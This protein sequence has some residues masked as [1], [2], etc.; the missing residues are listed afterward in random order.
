MIG[1]YSELFTLVKTTIG[2]QLLSSARVAHVCMY[3][4]TIK[5][6]LNLRLILCAV[7]FFFISAFFEL[8]CIFLYAS[9]FPRLACVKYYRSKAASEGSLTVTADLVAVGSTDFVYVRVSQ[10]DIRVILQ[11]YA[12]E[13]FSLISSS[14]LSASA[15]D[16]FSP[17][18]ISYLNGS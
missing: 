4:L 12:S 1:S 8:T 17:E 9:L 15:C 18:S 2:F 5:L 6:R 16:Q 10:I 3:T 11:L 13:K 14:G 7:V